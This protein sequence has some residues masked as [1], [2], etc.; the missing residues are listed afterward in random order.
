MALTDT[1]RQLSATRDFTDQVE[2]AHTR[3]RRKMAN[4]SISFH[5]IMLNYGRGRCVAVDNL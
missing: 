5:S 2:R 1:F 4:A 3:T